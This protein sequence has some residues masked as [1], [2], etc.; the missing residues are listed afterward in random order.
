M[1]GEDLIG[2]VEETTTAHRDEV[3]HRSA[4]LTGGLNAI[5]R[6]RDELRV[7]KSIVH[8]RAKLNLYV[9]ID[10]EVLEDREIQVV[11]ARQLQRVASRRRARAEL[12]LNVLR[13]RV[14]RDI[15]Y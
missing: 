12:R 14:D 2:T 1:A 15:G 5:D 6:A 3:R 11:D 4:G 9:F 10:R 13:G 7:V 8:V